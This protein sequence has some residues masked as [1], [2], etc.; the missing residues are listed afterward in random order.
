VCGVP[1]VVPEGIKLLRAGGI[2]VLGGMVHPESKLNL[3]GEQIIR[4]CVTIKGMQVADS[5]HIL[6]SSKV[7]HYVPQWSCK[8]DPV[9]LKGDGR[10]GEI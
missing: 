7:K 2:Y 5:P 3:T 10:Q 9:T 1:G 6:Y 8:L 4:K